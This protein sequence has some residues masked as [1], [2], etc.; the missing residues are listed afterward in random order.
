MK[1]SATNAEDHSTSESDDNPEVIK[2]SLQVYQEQTKPLIE[3]FKEKKIPFV[4]SSTTSLEQ[5]PEPIVEKMIAELKKLKF[6]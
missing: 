1:A 5:S 3:F 6:A 4:I 2:K